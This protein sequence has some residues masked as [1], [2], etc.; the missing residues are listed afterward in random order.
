MVSVKKCPHGSG[1]KRWATL[2][3]APTLEALIS[4]VT[5]CIEKPIWDASKRLGCLQQYADAKIGCSTSC[6]VSELLVRSVLLT[7]VRCLSFGIWQMSW[8]NQFKMFQQFSFGNLYSWLPL[9]KQSVVKGTK[10]SYAHTIPGFIITVAF[11]QEDVWHGKLLTF[12]P[13][14]PGF[15]SHLNSSLVSFF[16]YQG[17]HRWL[18][19]LQTLNSVCSLGLIKT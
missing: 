15:L 19:E 18:I 8:N 11:S 14:S 10:N 4:A 16:T 3:R 9:W 13:R 7:S 2:H 1:G 17:S 12:N 6:Q 5:R